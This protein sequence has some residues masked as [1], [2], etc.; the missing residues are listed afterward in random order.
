MMELV[1]LYVVNKKVSV[2]KKVRWNLNGKEG[3]KGRG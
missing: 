2:D 3:R 1:W